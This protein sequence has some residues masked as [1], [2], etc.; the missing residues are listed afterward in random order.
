MSDRKL[1]HRIVDA[2]GNRF[3]VRFKYHEGEFTRLTAKAYAMENTIKA[4]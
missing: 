3:Y 1:K 4:I 2:H